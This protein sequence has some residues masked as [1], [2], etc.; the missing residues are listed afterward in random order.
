MLAVIRRQLINSR[1]EMTA[2]EDRAQLTDIPRTDR[3]MATTAVPA[4]QR[5]IEL[6]ADKTQRAVVHTDEVEWTPSPSAGVFRRMIERS[7]GE[8][9][10]ASTI[11]RFDPHREFSRHTHA[12]GEEFLVLD[13][14]WQDDYGVFPVGSYVSPLVAPRPQTASV[15]LRTTL[16]LMVGLSG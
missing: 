10:R 7:G 11:V 14:V 15:R 8:V 16:V 12:G 9:A 4:A 6:H 5:V 1:S 3:T 2:S 13:G